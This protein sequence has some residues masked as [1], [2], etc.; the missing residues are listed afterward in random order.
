MPAKLAHAY[1]LF[2]VFCRDR[3]ETPMV[4]H[5]TRDNLGWPSVRAYPTCSFKGSDTRLIL[6]FVL[7]V[8]EQPSYILDDLEEHIY[9]AVKSID[10]FLRHVFGS[11]C[12]SRCRKVLLDRNEGVHALTLLTSWTEKFYQCAQMCFDKQL[13]FFPLTPKYH[14]LLHVAADLRGQ[15]NKLGDSSGCVL[16]PA[17]FATQMAEDATGRSCRIARSCH[18]RTASLRVAQKWLIAIKLFWDDQARG[19]AD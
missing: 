16:N 17:V 13:C 11:K 2:R 12:D 3:R 6:G 7:Q 14:Y 4:K 9:I 10:D 5:F 8:L 19:E 1:S 15:L 18:V